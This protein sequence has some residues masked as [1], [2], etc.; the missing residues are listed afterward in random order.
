MI[1]LYLDFD[2]KQQFSVALPMLWLLRR[3]W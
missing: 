3:F 2:L 1:I